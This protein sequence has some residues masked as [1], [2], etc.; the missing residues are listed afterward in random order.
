MSE[1]VAGKRRTVTG[2]LFLFPV[3]IAAALRV[4]HIDASFHVSELLTCFDKRITN[5][6]GGGMNNK[7][8]AV[9]QRCHGFRT[10]KNYITA[11]YPCLG[12]LPESEAAHRFL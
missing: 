1:E 9:S 10:V 2:A 4:H 8:K 7:G 11:L 5:D 6:A 3:L 12:G